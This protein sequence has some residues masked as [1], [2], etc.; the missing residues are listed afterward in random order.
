[1]SSLII[2]A[3]DLLGIDWLETKKSWEENGLPIPPVMISVVN[4]TQTAKRIKYAFDHKRI[5]IDELCVSE[6]ILHIDSEVLKKVED[7]IEQEKS[8][9][10]FAEGLREKVDTVGQ[11]GKAGEQIQNVISVGML[12]EGWDAKTVTHIMGL[13]AFSSQLLCEQV[14]GRGLRRTS[15]EINPDTGL[16]DAEH[17]NIFGIP[18]SILPYEENEKQ[19][20]KVHISLKRVEP[21]KEKEDFEISYPNIIRIEHVFKPKLMIELDKIEPLIL[22]TSDSSLIAELS[23]ILDGN[24]DSSKISE[25][26]LFKSG[27]QY[28]HQEFIFK[29][30]VNIYDQMKKEWKGNKSFLVAQLVKIIDIFVNSKKCIIKPLT[31]NNDEVKRRVILKLNMP[32]IEQHLKGTIHHQ[33]AEDLIPVF[34]RLKPICSTKD[35]IPWNTKK[36][37][38]AFKKCH[39]NYCV[40]D[41]SWEQTVA[42]A[43]DHDINV[44]KWVKNDHLGFE[45]PYFFQGNVHKYKPDFILEFIN[46]NFMIIEVK[47]QEDEKD[48]AKKQY[49]DDWVKAVNSHG[50]FGNWYWRISKSPTE[51]IDILND[52]NK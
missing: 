30:A 5:Q 29:T 45:I 10:E 25:I 36:P 12:S 44:K 18:F 8:K 21:L 51:V 31:Y 14:V 4:K 16:F 28:R 32:K 41:S 15:Y 11:I 49:L 48:K 1:L 35:M 2:N 42:N 6:K 33:N 9:R 39:I 50:G 38:Q 17:V 19:M 20:Y 3:Y 47:G 37:C 40:F 52:F 43:L 26:N 24:V 27:Y 22:D 46:G 7:G 34:E 13:R 23:P